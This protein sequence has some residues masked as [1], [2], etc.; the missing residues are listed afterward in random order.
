VEE[1]NSRKSKRAK[2]IFRTVAENVVVTKSII[3]ALFDQLNIRASFEISGERI[4]I[5]IS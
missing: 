1:E 4:F 3:K 5:K 2:F